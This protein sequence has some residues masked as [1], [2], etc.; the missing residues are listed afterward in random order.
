M[1][2]GIAVV[3]VD[4]ASTFSIDWGNVYV[5]DS[6]YNR[7]QLSLKYNKRYASSI[8]CLSVIERIADDD[9]QFRS[10]DGL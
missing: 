5:S 9:R 7:F 1:S 3:N 4:H 8:T 10:L 6:F 2:E